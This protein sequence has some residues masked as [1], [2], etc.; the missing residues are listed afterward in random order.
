MENQNSATKIMLTYGVI[1]GVVSIIISL[2]NYSFGNIFKPHWSISLLN[3]LSM[4]VVIVLAVKAFKVSNAGFLTLGEAVKIGLGV[5]LIAAIIG[6]IYTLIFMKVIEPNFQE[7]MKA[8]LEQTYYE[9]FPDM[10][11]E[12]IEKMVEMGKKFSSPGWIAIFSLG[13]SLLF[14]LIIS[15]ITGAF[16]KKEEQY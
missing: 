8:F 1:L 14:G 7:E 15:L 4:I 16:M 11:E 5:A 9:K 6:I 2:I 13:G 3:F 10:P 12:Q